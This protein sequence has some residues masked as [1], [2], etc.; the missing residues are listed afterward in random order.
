MEREKHLLGRRRAACHRRLLAPAAAVHP[1]LAAQ[2]ALLCFSG[3]C[4][5]RRLAADAAAVLRCRS[6]RFLPWAFSGYVKRL[7]FSQF[8]LFPW[9]GYAFLGAAVSR[10]WQDAKRGQAEARFFRLLFFAGFSLV[11]VFLVIVLQPF[12]PVVLGTFNPSGRSSSSSSWAS[13]SCSS[14]C[15]GAGSR[16][17]GI[18]RPW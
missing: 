3:R 18:V 16:K 6:K 7:P 13:S 9:L 1:A 2:G 12:V 10:L 11:A 17:R 8:P 5:R 14:P 4:R 15:C